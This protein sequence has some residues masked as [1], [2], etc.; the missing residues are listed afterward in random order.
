MK[1]LSVFIDESGDFGPYEQHAPYYIVAMVFHNQNLNI[2]NLIQQL[3][4][5]LDQFGFP[6]HCVHTGPIIRNEHPY[7]N[8]DLVQRRKIFGHLLGFV[9]QAEISYKCFLFQKHKTTNAQQMVSALT[10]QISLFLNDNQQFFDSF[11]QIKVYYDNGQVELSKLLK[12]VF[13]TQYTNVEFRKVRPSDFK[14]FQAADMFCSM[15]LVEKHLADNKLSR[16]EKIFFDAEHGFSSL[17]K[18]YLKPIKKK[19]LSSK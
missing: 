10:Q 19:V 8:C 6:D 1:E 4:Q 16:S 3:N 17:K 18:N 13:Q 14:L 5:K 11:D 7:N 15:Y 9:R 2:D 12:E